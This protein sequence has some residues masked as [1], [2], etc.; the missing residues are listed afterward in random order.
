MTE[1]EWEENPKGN[2][3]TTTPSESSIVV[4]KSREGW[5]Y[6]ITKK[7]SSE[8]IFGKEHFKTAE[9]GKAFVNS[10]T[11]PQGVPPEP[12]KD[13]FNYAQGHNLMRQLLVSQG[14]A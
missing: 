12:I 9:E 6:C 13:T 7:Y 11:D 10:R 8:P 3:G 4:F 2:W 5:S 1:L 14:H